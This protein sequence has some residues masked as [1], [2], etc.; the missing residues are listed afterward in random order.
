MST[1]KRSKPVRSAEAAL[2]RFGSV[3][4]GTAAPRAPAT[5]RGRT[6]TFFVP[7]RTFS[8][9]KFDFSKK[10]GDS[11]GTNMKRSKS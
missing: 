4:R 8:Q 9:K 6:F 11:R 5:M 3:L 2:T 7:G 10:I 1:G